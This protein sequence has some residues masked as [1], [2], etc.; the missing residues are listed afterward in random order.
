MTF[1]DVIVASLDTFGGQGVGKRAIGKLADDI[2]AAK[3]PPKV[4]DVSPEDV[5]LIDAALEAGPYVSIVC[6]QIMEY[7]EAK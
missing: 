4:M 3:K 7:L 1:A 5:K 2:M 6:K